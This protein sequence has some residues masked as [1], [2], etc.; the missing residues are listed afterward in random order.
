MPP[1]ENLYDDFKGKEMQI[2]KSL[3]E[4]ANKP[5]GDQPSWE[6]EGID[7]GIQDSMR[8]FS[9]ISQIAEG[10]RP[11]KEFFDEITKASKEVIQ[12][13]IGPKSQ[14]RNEIDEYLKRNNYK[15]PKESAEDNDGKMYAF[16]CEFSEYIHKYNEVKGNLERNK[17]K[18]QSV[19]V[20]YKRV[21]ENL[22]TEISEILPDH[23]DEFYKKL[24]EVV[25]FKRIKKKASG[26]K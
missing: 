9:V 20:E 16:Y 17:W 19:I 6:D 21:E 5:I 24:L 26:S 13:L 8:Q 11:S 4:A 7:D 14:Y 1:Y 12:K 10:A 23:D 2:T 3:L 25:Q 15:N 22:L 18:E